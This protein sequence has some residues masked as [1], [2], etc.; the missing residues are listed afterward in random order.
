MLIGKYVKLQRVFQNVH[1]FG[2]AILL[3]MVVPLFRFADLPICPSVLV[4]CYN[5]I[6]AAIRFEDHTIW[7]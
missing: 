4:L 2:T 1:W 5:D 7:P 3:L 6:I